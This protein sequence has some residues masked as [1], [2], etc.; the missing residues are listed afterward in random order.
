MLA[1]VFLAGG[2][3]H[4]VIKPTVSKLLFEDMNHLI[5]VVEVFVKT[6]DMAAFSIRIA[7]SP[8][9]GH[10]QKLVGRGIFSQGWPSPI[11]EK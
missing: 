7:K 2:V 1:V 4:P 3:F 5:Q 6:S 11:Q 9:V 10:I 8:Q